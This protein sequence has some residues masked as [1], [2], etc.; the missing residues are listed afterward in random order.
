MTNAYNTEVLDVEVL[1]EISA[2]SPF[3]CEF[4]P[5]TPAEFTVE[6]ARGVMEK[7]DSLK[8][9][10]ITVR[11]TPREYGHAR[12]G[13][14]VFETEDFRKLYKIVGMTGHG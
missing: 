11:F 2:F 10:V 6:P 5:D 12:V 9:T 1:N 14:L 4:L 8:P 13:W 7:R 3:R